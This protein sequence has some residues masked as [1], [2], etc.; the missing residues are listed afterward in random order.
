[1]GTIQS[2]KRRKKAIMNEQEEA[3]LVQY[4]LDM[5]DRAH[6]LN[7]MQLIMKVA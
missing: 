5:C 3:I 6:P 1:M 7:M 4:I 2:R